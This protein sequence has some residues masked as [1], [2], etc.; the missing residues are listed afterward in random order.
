MAITFV[1]VGAAST[2]NGSAP[3][4]G[5]PAGLATDDIMVAVFYSRE[6]VDGTVAISAGWTQAYNERSTGG[7]LGVWWRA[8]VAGDAAPTFTLTGHA[9]GASGDTAIAQ[10][11][12]WR[13]VDTF[14]PIYA[15]GVIATNGSSQNIGPITGAIRLGLDDILVVVGGKIDDWASVAT[16]SGDG[17][18]W[19][20]IGEPDAI[21]GADAGIVWNRTDPSSGYF[22]I[23][24]K[25]FSVTGGTAVAGKGVMLV[26]NDSA[27]NRRDV[28]A[29]WM[30]DFLSAQR[31]SCG[32]LT[33]PDIRAGVDARYLNT[34]WPEPAN[35][36][37]SVAQK[38]EIDDLIT[39]KKA[40]TDHGYW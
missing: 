30:K 7:L 22:Q 26:L 14:V 18:T 32:S 5:L 34:A 16:L 15:K 17:L 6:S 20:E 24:P 1:A 35:T 13:G 8:F 3:S 11:A 25:T 2:T 12:A 28:M 27:G 33:K 19:T 4:P 10:I 39:Q 31:A 23:S 21:S 36:Q 40:G 38:T 9:T 29:T 37:L